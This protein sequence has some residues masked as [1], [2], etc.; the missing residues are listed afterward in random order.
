[1]IVCNCCNRHIKDDE[2]TCPFCNCPDPRRRGPSALLVAV[3][4][5]GL[6]ATQGCYGGPPHPRDDIRPRQ[7]DAT[8]PVK[9]E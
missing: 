8:A 2:A 9:S 6:A 3:A 1:M 7:P 4:S 5:I